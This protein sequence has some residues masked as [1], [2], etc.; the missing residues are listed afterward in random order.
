[1]KSITADRRQ[2]CMLS[3]PE[4]QFAMFQTLKMANKIL[5][6]PYFIKNTIFSKHYRYKMIKKSNIITILAG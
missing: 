4:V 1:M 6:H 2:V 3:L 5:N